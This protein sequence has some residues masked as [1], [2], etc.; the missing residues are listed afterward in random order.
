MT[1]TVGPTERR[2]A[3]EIVTQKRLTLKMPDVCRMI[4]IS[5]AYGYS[6]VRELKHYNG[7]WH[8]PEKWIRVVLAFGEAA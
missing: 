5:T 1:I 4:G 3:A 6:I 2:K 8:C 7:T